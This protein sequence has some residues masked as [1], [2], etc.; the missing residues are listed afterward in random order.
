M[1]TTPVPSQRCPLHMILDHLAALEGALFS[2]L[3]PPPF[4]FAR[5]IVLG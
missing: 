3:I 4:G 1:H 5:D 2:W